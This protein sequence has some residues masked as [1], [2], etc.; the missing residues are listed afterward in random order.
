MALQDMG[1]WQ[2][3]SAARLTGIQDELAALRRDF[4]SKLQYDTGKQQQLD[5]MHQELESYRR[6]L[7]LQLLRP[8]FTDLIAFYADLDKVIQR[9]KS[10]SAQ[11]EDL[12]RYQEQIEEI[13]RRNGVERYDTTDD[14]LDP[15]RQRV[16]DTVPTADPAQDKRIAERL[17]PGFEYEGRIVFQPEQ[18][19]T[20]CYS[21]ATPVASAVRP[22][23]QNEQN[24]QHAQNE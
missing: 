19:K 13:L 5:T 18:V 6:G 20:Y 24:A 8:I 12:A 2:A 23:P 4:E 21:P 10:E 11:T 22:A 9:R 16:I 17:K 14:T 15:K 7:H 3:E 1:A